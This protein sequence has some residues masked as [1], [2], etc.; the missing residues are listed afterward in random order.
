LSK[1]GINV[2]QVDLSNEEAVKE[3]VVSNESAFE[4][5]TSANSSTNSVLVNVVVH[6]ASAIDAR[7]VT[8]I[9]K[10]LGHRRKI[11]KEETY[12]IHVS[13]LGIFSPSSY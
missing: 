1:L 5:S 10:A 11:S 6:T 8:A 13:F 4:R 3:A 12:Y 7:V 2:I 9:I